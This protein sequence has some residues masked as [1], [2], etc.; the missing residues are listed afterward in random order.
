MVAVGRAAYTAGHLAEASQRHRRGIA[1][2]TTEGTVQGTVQ[3]T[4]EASQRAPRTV[5]VRAA[6]RVIGGHRASVRSLLSVTSD[7]EDDH[8][9]DES[10]RAIK[11]GEVPNAKLDTRVCHGG[12]R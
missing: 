6:H 5:G 4:A 9:G 10:I 11:G 2:G 12:A 1:E 8:E 3:G 7:V